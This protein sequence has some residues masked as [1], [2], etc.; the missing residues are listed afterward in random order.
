VYNQNLDRSI[1][2]FAV[3]L[4][5]GL[6]VSNVGFHAPRNHPGFPNDGTLGDAGFS[7]TA[8]TANQ[9]GKIITWNTETFAQNQNANA[10]RWG[11][12][13]NFRFDSDRSPIDTN[14]YVEFFKTGTGV[15]VPVL[16]PD[17][18]NGV[19]P[20]PTPTATATAPGPSPSASATA[21]ASPS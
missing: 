1:Q 9:D 17:G 20:S 8:W 7:N 6:T 18:C 12:I 14:A 5:C 19:T 16:G 21:T 3:T 15:S 10:I 4:G 13:Y 11:T 2:S